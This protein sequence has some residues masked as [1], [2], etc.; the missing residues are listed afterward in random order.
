M[1]KHEGLGGF[2]RK[3]FS[4]PPRVGRGIQLTRTMILLFLSV[5]VVPP[6][7]QAG[8]SITLISGSEPE[9]SAMAVRYYGYGDR[10]A[11]APDEQ[12]FLDVSNWPPASISTWAADVNLWHS[13]PSPY[14]DAL[15]V[16]NL[17]EDPG[18]SA[19]GC[20][21]LFAAPFYVPECSGPAHRIGKY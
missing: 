5:A 18:N 11:H 12:A 9:N 16:F 8:V 17:D 14:A 15:P 4:P 7:A 10:R 6:L 21:S 2:L 19:W 20:S 1:P 13:L 3:G